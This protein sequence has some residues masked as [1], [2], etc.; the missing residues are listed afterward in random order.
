MG[1]RGHGP[2]ALAAS[3]ARITKPLFAKRGFADGAILSDWP[4]IVGPQL[5]AHSSP[6][7]IVFP[8]G[9]RDGGTLHLSVDSG[10]FAVE[11]QHLEPLLIERINTYFGYRA[12]GRV[13]ILQRQFSFKRPAN[14]PKTLNRDGPA[15][16]AGGRPLDPEEE[17]NLAELLALVDDPDLRETLESLGRALMARNKGGA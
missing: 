16:V 12:V 5:A 13:R 1:N 8:S 3:V 6:E 2:R 14:E 17:K 9:G 4:S 10:S 15:H 11:L 7:K